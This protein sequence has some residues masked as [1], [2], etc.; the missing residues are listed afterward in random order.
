MLLLAVAGLLST[1]S[2]A[3]APHLVVR[4]MAS[5]HRTI[6]VPPPIHLSASSSEPSRSIGTRISSVISRAA[7]FCD[8]NYFLVGVVTSVALAGI[9]PSI[10]RKGGILRPEI[11]VAWGATCSIFLLAGLNLPTSELARA[12]ASVRLHALIQTC[13]LALIPLITLLIC[14]GL[15]AVGWLAPA[16]RDGMLVMSVLPT[17]VNMCVAL[18]R[19]SGGDEALAIFN[20]VLGNLLGVVLTPY[21]LL[22]LVGAQAGISVVDTLVKLGQKVVLPLLIG[23]VLRPPLLKQGVLSGGSKK[24]LSRT[25]ETC[26]LVIVYSTFCDTFLRGFGLPAKTLAGLFTIVG[27]THAAGLLAV[28]QVGGLARLAAAQRITLTLCATQ[29]TLALGLPLLKIIFASRPDLGLLCTP[30]LI[31]HPLQLVVGSLL[32]PKFNEYAE[33]EKQ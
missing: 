29:K 10:G 14:N 16:L 7:T 17:T 23:Q 1:Q 27:A 8:K 6:A 15:S 31:Q 22:R 19:S 28:W 26:L 4:P 5:T 33:Q 25:S 21:L 3:F 13:N 18:S 11:T 9:N 24:L 30:L 12:A 20:A 2:A 32:S